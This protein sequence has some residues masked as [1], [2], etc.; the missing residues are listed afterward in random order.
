[1]STNFI[2]FE[3]KEFAH[4]KNKPD[5]YVCYRTVLSHAL[6]NKMRCSSRDDAKNAFLKLKKAVESNQEFIDNYFVH[7][8]PVK[9]N[10]KIGYLIIDKSHGYYP[11]VL[12]PYKIKGESRTSAFKYVLKDMADNIDSILTE[13]QTQKSWTN[14]LQFNLQ[15]KIFHYAEDT[16]KSA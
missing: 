11:L 8:Y 15:D 6:L 5:K 2:I 7:F 12:Y 1:M 9:M 3:E 16:K 4:R 10:S 14:K 13:L